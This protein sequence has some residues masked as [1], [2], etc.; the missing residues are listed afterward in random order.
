MPRAR[1][2]NGMTNRLVGSVA[3][4]EIGREDARIFHL[5][6]LLL[7]PCRCLR[8]IVEMELVADLAGVCVRPLSA[9]SHDERRRAEQLFELRARLLRVGITFDCD[10]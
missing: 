10:R 2:A 5:G 4:D 3:T 7:V 1:P 8:A 6:E 9:G